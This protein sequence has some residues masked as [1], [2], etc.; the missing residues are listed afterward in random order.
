MF[1]IMDA[2]SFKEQWMAKNLGASFDGPEV[3]AVVT[4]IP[5]QDGTIGPSVQMDV[6]GV[7]D[8]DV[9]SPIGVFGNEPNPVAAKYNMP[10]FVRVATPM[11]GAG[12][13]PNPMV[14][15]GIPATGGF[16][17]EATR[18]HYPGFM[19]GVKAGNMPAYHR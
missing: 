12:S 13:S 9:I 16:N 8:T 19:E 17:E 2:Q 5:A 11:R 14:P 18:E 1:F 6:L 15:G 7:G 4:G 10:P 3:A